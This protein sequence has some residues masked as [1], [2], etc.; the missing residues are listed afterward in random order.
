MLTMKAYNTIKVEL[1]NDPK[2][3]AVKAVN[4]WKKILD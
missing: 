3:S 2:Q 4:N 1:E